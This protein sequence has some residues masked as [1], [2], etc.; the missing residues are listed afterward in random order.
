[1]IRWRRRREPVETVTVV[2][3]QTRID[4]P[5]G[6]LVSVRH[7]LMWGDDAIAVMHCSEMVAD[8]LAELLADHGLGLDLPDTIDGRAL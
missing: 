2:Q 3:V 1:M 7:H 4:H 5:A 8:R 6:E